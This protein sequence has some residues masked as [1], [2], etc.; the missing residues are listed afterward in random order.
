VTPL[1]P[2]LNGHGRSPSLKSPAVK[3]P[4]LRSPQ[5]EAKFAAATVYL[6]P[7]TLEDPPSP[8]GRLSDRIDNLRLRCIEGLGVSAFK[9]AYQVLKAL[10]VTSNKNFFSKPRRYQY[11]AVLNS[12]VSWCDHLNPPPTHPT[13]QI[14][15]RTPT[16]SLRVEGRGGAR[17]RGWRR[18]LR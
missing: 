11:I 14:T 5:R 6:R 1:R 16:K 8:A 12:Q 17:M 15:A 4:S 13:N 3:S 10:Q 7:S 18:E 2:K 9:Q